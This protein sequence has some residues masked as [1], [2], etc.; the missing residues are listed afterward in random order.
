GFNAFIA[1]PCRSRAGVF[2]ESQRPD[3]VKGPF[4]QVDSSTG[5]E[6]SE[7]MGYF[8]AQWRR[9]NGDAGKGNDHVVL[10]TVRGRGVYL[11]SFF[12]VTSLERYWWGGGEIKCVT[13]GD[14]QWP[15]LTRPGLEDA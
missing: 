5:D 8:H 4:Y 13:D 12:S 6:L 9:T 1:M 14:Q 11:G 3:T 7:D 2:I 10:D 15:S